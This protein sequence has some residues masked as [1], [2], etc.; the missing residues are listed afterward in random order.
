MLEVKFK[1]ILQGN[2]QNSIV[3][4]MNQADSALLPGYAER[5]A[6][7]VSLLSSSDRRQAGF[8]A[9][10]SPGNRRDVCTTGVFLREVIEGY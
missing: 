9:L 3:L 5:I 6:R 10:S 1:K 7:D 4:F 8:P 2:S